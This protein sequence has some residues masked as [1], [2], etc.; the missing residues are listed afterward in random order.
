MKRRYIYRQN[1]KGEVE[2]FEVSS[3]YTG[4]DR[5]TGDL[6][7]FQ[8]DNLQAT[9]G[10]DISSRTKH[11]KYM[12]E[13]GLSLASDFTETWAAAEKKRQAFR[14]GELTSEASQ[15]LKNDLGRAWH[16]I[17]ETKNGR[18]KH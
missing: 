18:R 8:Y 9:D 2:S 13:N 5:S 7:K 6:S 15:K 10:A 3:D 17:Q 11:K 4:A 12:K 1:E 14:H 16:Q